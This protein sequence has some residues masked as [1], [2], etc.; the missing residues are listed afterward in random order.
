MGEAPVP[1]QSI[2]RVL[3][4]SGAW[5][6]SGTR[7][8]RNHKTPFFTSSR[9]TGG[10]HT[11]RV[12]AGRPSRGWVRVWV[13]SGTGS[14]GGAERSPPWS[15]DTT[16]RHNQGVMRKGSNMAARTL[17]V[18][19]LRIATIR[20]S[21]HTIINITFKTKSAGCRN[22]TQLTCHKSQVSIRGC[23]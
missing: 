14:R 4:T 1:L 17:S 12:R 15:P 5:A 23:S 19:R 13:S 9:K 21:V 10:C 6:G 16:Q 3:G 8:R 7:L 2:C 20:Q 18:R 11:W 22:T